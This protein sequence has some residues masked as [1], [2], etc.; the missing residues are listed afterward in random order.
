MALSRVRG[1]GRLGRNGNGPGLDGAAARES[2]SYTGSGNACCEMHVH[3]NVSIGASEVARRVSLDEAEVDEDYGIMMNAGR[4]APQSAGK[5]TNSH[6][7][8]IRL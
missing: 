6:I 1:F 3:M 4:I 8:T 7:A 2:S 5:F